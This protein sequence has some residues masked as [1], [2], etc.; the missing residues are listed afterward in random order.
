MTGSNAALARCYV[1]EV[2][3]GRNLDV[4][5]ELYAED[6]ANHIP[7]TGGDVTGSGLRE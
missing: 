1:E 2:V 7:T 5:A 4:I 6:Y 3:N